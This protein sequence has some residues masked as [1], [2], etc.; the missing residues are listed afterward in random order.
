[1]DGTQQVVGMILA[2]PIWRGWEHVDYNVHIALA[3]SAWGKGALD[4]AAKE[5]IPALFEKPS[6]LRLSGFTTS[7]YRPG[8]A[9]A[10]RLGFT[11]EGTIP[12]AVRVDGVAKSLTL[13]GLTRANWEASLTANAKVIQGD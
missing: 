13:T 9:C 2:D 11:I 7:H 8:I 4:L 3:W 5:I 6:I 10:L 12:D 1:M